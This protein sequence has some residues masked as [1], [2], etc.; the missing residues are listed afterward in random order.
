MV[1]YSRPGAQYEKLSKKSIFEFFWIVISIQG[2]QGAIWEG[3]E[4]IMELKNIKTKKL[5]NIKII[6]FRRATTTTII[7]RPRFKK[8]NSTCILD[9]SATVQIQ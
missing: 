6:I 2:V 3:P 8:T 1:D 4:P 5:G 9:G 7:I